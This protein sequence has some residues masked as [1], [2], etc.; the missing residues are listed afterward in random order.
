MAR[1]LIDRLLAADPSRR[2][3]TLKNG[4]LEVKNH[5]WFNGFSFKHLESKQLPA[6]YVPKIKSATDDSNFD[7]YDDEGKKNFPQV[8][9]VIPASTPITTLFYAQAAYTSGC[10]SPYTSPNS[11]TSILTDTPLFTS[12]NTQLYTPAYTPPFTS[13]RMLMRR[14]TSHETCLPSLL[15]SGAISSPSSRSAPPGNRIWPAD[16]R[17]IGAEPDPCDIGVGSVR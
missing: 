11:P 17:E 6:P 12:P 9:A 10:N 5:P 15:M 3:G 14:R 2:L 8:L 1:S 4:P 13:Y 7:H 16:S